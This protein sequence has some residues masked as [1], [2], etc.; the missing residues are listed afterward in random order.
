MRPSEQLIAVLTDVRRQYPPVDIAQPAVFLRNL[1]FLHN[2]IV[3]SEH[4]LEVA[5]TRAKGDL[6]DYYRVHLEEERQHEKWLADDLKS[7]GVKVGSLPISPEAVAMAGSQYYLIYHVDPVALLGYMA[8]LECFPLADEQMQTL[9]EIHGKTLCRTIRYHATHDKEH[10]A[11][12]LK[13]VDSLT[14]E[15]FRLVLDNA[16]QTA[17]YIGAAVSKF[18]A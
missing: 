9:E 2:V 15:H 18:S 12:V 5:I 8:V 1:V 16:V 13:M 6:L 7:V 11:D 4:L 3:A 14:S 10:G 17:L